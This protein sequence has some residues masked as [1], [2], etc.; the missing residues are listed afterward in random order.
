MGAYD[1]AV[2][3]GNEALDV[4]LSEKRLECAR[5]GI[6]LT[7]IADGRT[8][9]ALGPADLYA[10]VGGALDGAIDA[11]RAL[12]EGE[13]TVSLTLRETRG[14]A[15][16]HVENRCADEVQLADGLPVPPR[17]GAGDGA[18]A[19]EP[20]ARSMRLVAERL[21]GSVSFSAEGDILIVDVLLP[22]Q[23]TG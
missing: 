15:V 23:A 11:S 8:L 17:T 9:A 19:G 6:E 2:R 16:M 4:I 5:T 14:L 12:P 21:G 13:R 18:P 20:A 10:L 3:T 7:C 22:L 1:A